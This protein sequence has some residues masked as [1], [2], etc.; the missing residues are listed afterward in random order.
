M[1]VLSIDFWRTLLREPQ[2]PSLSA[3][4]QVLVLV[5][6]LV[7]SARSLQKIPFAS[8]GLSFHSRYAAN[9]SFMTNAV[10]IIGNGYDKV[11]L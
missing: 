8:Y 4:F 7:S 9:L 5:Q 1:F 6:L 11:T 3:L 2:I 10:S